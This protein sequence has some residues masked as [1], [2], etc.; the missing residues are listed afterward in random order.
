MNNPLRLRELQKKNGIKPKESKEEKKKRKEEKK[1][2]KEER[3]HRKERGS[4]SPSPLNYRRRSLSPDD[5]HSRRSRHSRSPEQSL[6]RLPPPRASHYDDR[7]RDRDRDYR[8]SRRYRD[9]RSLSP[10]R[11]RG[12]P[13]YSYGGSKDDIDRSR[14]RS[15]TMSAS[16]PPRSQR[17]RSL[18]RDRDSRERLHDSYSKR[19]R[20]SSPS[21]HHSSSHSS[22]HSHSNGTSTVGRAEADRAARLAAMTNDAS[23]MESERQVRLKAL[24]EKEKAELAADEAARAKSKGFG[25]FLSGEQKKVFGGIALEDQI[26]RGRGGMVVDA[27]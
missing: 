12:E 15:R 11:R 26:R 22:H 19:P 8:D 7:D 23:T 16:P 6:H 2:L 5:R 1:R 27:D 3:R 9:N 13:D 17:K 24:L 20:T 14:S 18:S 25:S 10:P 4:R 21:R